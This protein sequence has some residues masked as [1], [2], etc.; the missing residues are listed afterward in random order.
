MEVF[1]VILKPDPN[2]IHIMTE[3]ELIGL[4]IPIINKHIVGKDLSKC[5]L[6]KLNLTSSSYIERLYCN[7]ITCFKNYDLI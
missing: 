3:I 2:A 4:R 7:N 5:Q 6:N 1:A